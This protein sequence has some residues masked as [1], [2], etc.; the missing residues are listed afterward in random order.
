MLPDQIQQRRRGLIQAN[1][2][3]MAFALRPLPC[4]FWINIADFLAVE[5][6]NG[7]DQPLPSPAREIGP[8]IGRVRH[9]RPPDQA[10]GPPR[11]TPTFA[12][13]NTRSPIT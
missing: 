9:R 2:H 13:R 3:D 12:G 4:V 7:V 1:P 10:F 11:V 6:D 8:E 5:V